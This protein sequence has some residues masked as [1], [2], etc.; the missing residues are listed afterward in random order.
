MPRRRAS[1][2]SSTDWPGLRAP[3]SSSA[4]RP[5]SKRVSTSSWPGSRRSKEII[6]ADDRND[7]AGYLGWFFLGGLIG[8]ASALLLAPKTG[9]EMRDQL[10]D[11]VLEHGGEFARRAQAVASDAQ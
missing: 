9:R 8:A 2:A 10:R 1:A 6:M 4:W 7:A 11:Q 3:A 5:G